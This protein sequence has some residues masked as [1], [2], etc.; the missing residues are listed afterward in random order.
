LL[1]TRQNGFLYGFLSFF[2][3]PLSLFD[4]FRIHTRV[5]FNVVFSALLLFYFDLMELIG[6]VAG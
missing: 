4:I 3:S 5:C 2:D 1:V 6:F